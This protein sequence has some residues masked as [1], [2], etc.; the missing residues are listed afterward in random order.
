MQSR[1]L[2]QLDLG[3]Y[4]LQSQEWHTLKIPRSLSQLSHTFTEIS[5]RHTQSSESISLTEVMPTKNWILERTDPLTLVQRTRAVV[6]LAQ[7][8]SSVGADRLV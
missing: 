4:A 3:F 6:T 8:Y 5:K 2:R 1:A 7:G